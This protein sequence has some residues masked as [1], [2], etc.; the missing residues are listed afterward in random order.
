[1][2]KILKQFE[3]LKVVVVGDIM[4]DTYCYGRVDRISPEAP[5]PIVLVERQENHPGGAAN[6]AMNLASLGAKPFICSVTGKD[7]EAEEL[8]RLFRENGVDTSGIILS[9]KRVTTVKT[10]VM[11][12]N[13]QMLRIDNE[14]SHLLEKEEESKLISDVESHLNDAAVLIFQDYDKGVLSPH[15]IEKIT[16]LAKQKNIPI[17]VDPKRRNF[18]SYK[19]VTL[20][21]PNLK[22][23]REGLGKDINPANKTEFESAI[24]K[25][26]SELSISNVMITMSEKGI[27]I[28][29]G[30]HF[31]YQPA[32]ERK[33]VDVSGAGDTVVSVA[34]LCTAVKAGNHITAAYANLA[35]GLVC[36]EV[37]AVPV[38]KMILDAEIGQLAE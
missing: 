15:S 17:V 16:S 7:R 29:D 1:M 3:G 13:T 23:L 14:I 9:E 33:I 38:N 35:G 21:K 26:M 27:M 18:H 8:L 34:A 28:T 36:E 32:H 30:K 31:E 20:F 19:H 6:V 25:L 10:R 12:Q 24:S 5:V 4:M 11:A 22:E 37:G 2:N